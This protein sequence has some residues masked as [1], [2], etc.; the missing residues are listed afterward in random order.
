MKNK[1]GWLGKKALTQAVSGAQGGNTLDDVELNGIRS[2]FKGQA[3]HG[4][5]V[6]SNSSG[7]FAVRL[8]LVLP[9]CQYIAVLNTTAPFVSI[10]QLMSTC[11][12]HCSG[13][14]VSMASSGRGA[15]RAL[16]SKWYKET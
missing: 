10:W 15:C 9:S 8:W 16:P 4:A 11:L 12:V 13:G 1:H 2:L 5:E 6:S 14:T 7:P 3:E